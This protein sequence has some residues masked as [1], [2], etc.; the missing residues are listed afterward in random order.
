[1]RR[2]RNTAVATKEEKMIVRT[3]PIS[4]IGQ[5]LGVA[6]AAASLAAGAVAAGASPGFD[7]GLVPTRLGSPD[8]HDAALVSSASSAG[9]VAARVGSPDPRDTHTSP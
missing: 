3:H 4:R 8:P 6:A 5:A 2:D 7:A 1:L 9:L